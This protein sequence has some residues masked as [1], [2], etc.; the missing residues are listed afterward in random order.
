MHAENGDP[1][2]VSASEIAAWSY[3]PESLRLTQLGRKPSNEKALERGEKT[4]ENTAR[5]E[6]ATRR[7]SVLGASLVIAALVL[8][9]IHLL[10]RMRPW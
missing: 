4:H 6:I 2:I 10:S 8:G 3:C 7:F 1:E 9:A 5:I